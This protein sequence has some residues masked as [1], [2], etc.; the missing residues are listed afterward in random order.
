MSIQLYKALWGMEGSCRDQL[1]RAAQAG[2][3]GIEA[4]CRRR[5][6]KPNLRSCW[7]NF[8]FITLPR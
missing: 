7:R 1:T 6:W 8:S 5:I 4:R 2:Y 3:A